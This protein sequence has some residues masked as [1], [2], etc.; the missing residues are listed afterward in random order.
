MF[1]KMFFDQLEKRLEKYFRRYP[2][3]ER[4]AVLVTTN[5]AEYLLVEIIEYD[6]RFITFSYWPREN[7]DLPKRWDEVPHSLT[8]VI[9]SYEDI[10]S[11]TFDPKLVREREIGFKKPLRE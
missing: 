1:D 6:E 5:Q 7:A 2:E 3:A 11:V 9:I 8:A 10:R 4:V